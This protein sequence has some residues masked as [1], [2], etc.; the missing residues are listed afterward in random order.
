MELEACHTLGKGFTTNSKQTTGAVYGSAFATQSSSTLQRW[1]SF[2]HLNIHHTL[3]HTHPETVQ[4]QWCQ[5]RLL[6]L[7]IHGGIINHQSLPLV[8]SSLSWCEQNTVPAEQR[9]ALAGWQI[10]GGMPGLFMTSGSTS[11]LWQMDE[12]TMIRT[13]R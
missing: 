2:T 3:T 1:N 10:C 5:A 9:W 4:E 11:I 12:R 8:K 6:W 7:K 13:R